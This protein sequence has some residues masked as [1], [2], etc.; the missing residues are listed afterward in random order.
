MFSPMDIKKLYLRDQVLEAELPAFVMGIINITPNS[1]WQN[2]RYYQR[3]GE[4]GSWISSVVDAALKMQEDG[5]DI[6]DIG[7]ESS[8]PGSE[9]VAAEEEAA[10]IIPVIREFRRH[11]SCPISVDTRKKPVMEAALD[12]GADMLNDIS[13]LEDDPLLG[14]FAARAKIPVILM[15][16]RGHPSVMQERPDYADPVAEVEAYLQSR[17]SH[18]LSVGIGREKIILDSGIG[19]GK[20][21]KA[22][23]ALIVRGGALCG[24]E[25]PVLMALSRKTCIGEITGR[26]VQDRLA[27]TLAAN[28]AA[29][30]NGAALVRVHDVRETVDMLRVV[31][32]LGDE[33]F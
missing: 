33:R 22:N 4:T 13:A 2:S 30:L 14:P 24:G 32:S 21:L 27:G 17:I 26:E 29:A 20:N 5:A 25:Y 6:I 23:R 10:R 9:Y 8:R 1:F 12:V 19:F 3:E 18:A 31:R 16:K 15:H 28:M 11:S 7:A